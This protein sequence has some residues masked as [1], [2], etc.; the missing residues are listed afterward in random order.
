MKAAICA[1][2]G[3]SLDVLDVAFKAIAVLP[4]YEPHNIH[5]YWHTNEQCVTFL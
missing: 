1:L 3:F 4:T 5:K 2:S